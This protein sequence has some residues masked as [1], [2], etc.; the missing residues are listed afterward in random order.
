MAT[1][2]TGKHT[3]EVAVGWCQLPDGLKLGNTHGIDVDSQGRFYVHNTGEEQIVVLGPDG[4]FLNSWSIGFGTGA[5]GLFLS[6]E[7]DGEY[8]Y[9]TDTGNGGKVVK[10]TLDGK[11]VLELGIPDLPDVYGEGLK[12]SPTDVAVAPN[13]DFYVCD[14]YGQSW[15]HQ[16][17]K[18]GEHIR[19]W[20]GK[21]SDAGQMSCP[22]GIWIDTRKGKD[23]AEVYVADRSNQRIQ[24]FTLEGQ[25]L[26]FVQG[27]LDLPCCF[28]THGEE[29]YIPDLHSRV[30]ILDK[31]DKLLAHLGEDA[32]A[33]KKEGWPRR[34]ETEWADDRF[35]SPHGLCVDSE[36]SIYVAEWVPT[37]RITKLVRK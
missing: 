26:R 31:D 5:H 33:W 32:E 13:G 4:V 23:Q 35:V 25:H 37:G 14:G 29:L 20:G 18:D 6:Q 2:G 8:L 19:S 24:V 12:Y 34:P 10:T 11:I 36:G 1:M 16:Y 3:Y 21:G 22:H 15:I 27:M 9:L 7:S 28:Y 17:R 30:T